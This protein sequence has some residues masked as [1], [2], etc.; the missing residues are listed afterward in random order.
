MT[1]LS[2][3]ELRLVRY[4]LIHLKSSLDAGLAV[5]VAQEVAPETQS[6]GEDLPDVVTLITTTLGKL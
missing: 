4:A 5:E 3:Q 6:T 1:E 2:V